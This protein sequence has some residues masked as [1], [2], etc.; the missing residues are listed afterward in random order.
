MLTVTNSTFSGNSASGDGGGIFIN[1]GPATVTNSTFSGNT[2][3]QAAAAASQRGHADGHQQ[4]LLR[5]Q[6]RGDGGGISN[7]ADG[8]TLT[9]TNSTFSGNSALGGRGGGIYHS[10]DAATATLKGTILASEPDGGNCGRESITASYNIADDGTCF[11]NGT[12]GNA[13]V[14][15]TSDIDLDPLGLQNNGGPTK[16]IALMSS[17]VRPSMRFPP[18]PAPIPAACPP[19]PAP[20]PARSPTSSPATSAASRGPATLPTATSTATSALMSCSPP[21]LQLPAQAPRQLAR[22]RRPRRQLPHQPRPPHR[23]Q[24]QLARR[25]R[26]RRRPQLPR[27]GLSLKFSLP[28]ASS[29]HLSS[30]PARPSNSAW[31]TL[32]TRR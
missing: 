30:I 18:P 17:T 29:T 14:I 32:A 25:R 22:P 5:Q 28:S 21:R 13:V 4:H 12:N 24:R 3:T 31:L 26:P 2:A 23:P 8:G 1:A 6:R 19:T 7:R 27:R 16:T 20:L 15:Q 11:T 10:G 9:V